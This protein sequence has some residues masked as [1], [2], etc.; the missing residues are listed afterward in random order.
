MKNIF[1]AEVDSPKTGSNW[2][3]ISEL[4]RIKLIMNE[5]QKNDFSRNFEPIK[6][7]DNGQIVIKIENGIP[8]NERGPLLLDL[9][10][11]LKLSIDKGIT[12][13]CEP[14]GDKSKLRNLRGVKIKA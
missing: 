11:R 2:L 12:V 13:W 7:P 4:D 8:A 10:Q 14:I 1:Y 3:K 5:L 6:A 9:E